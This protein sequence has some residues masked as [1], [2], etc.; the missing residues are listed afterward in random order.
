MIKDGTY[1]IKA[2]GGVDATHGIELTNDERVLKYFESDFAFHPPKNSNISKGGYNDGTLDKFSQRI[3]SKIA[4]KRLDF[5]F[6]ENSKSI[7]FE[8]TLRQLM[9]Y[10]SSEC[11][12]NITIIDLS[13]IPFEVLSI[14]VS[15]ISRLI[16]EY[17]Y[18]YK[19]LRCMANP[20]EKINNNTPILMVYEEAH[21]YVPRSDLT[22]YRS[23][24]KAIERIAKEGRKYGVT[25]LLASQRPSEISETIFSQCN[26]FVAMRLTNPNDQAYVKRLLPDTLGNL[27]EKL[28][29][30]SAGEAILSGEAVV[31]PSIVKIEKCTLPPS[32]HDIPYWD[33]WKK[34]W[35]DVEY[36]KIISD[37]Y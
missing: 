28:P 19:R 18:Y 29:S 17:G 8:E 9:G 13:G 12:S 20:D 3:E 6:G 16:F 30:L 11:K 35:V 25:L 2:D 32:S 7:G 33:L 15:L 23:S 1:E 36:E 4:D 27:I 37:W 26:N 14:T 21:K 31:L 5:L 22:K 34:E 10:Y 24:Q